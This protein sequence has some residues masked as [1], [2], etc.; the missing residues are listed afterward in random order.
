MKL[1]PSK[2]YQL[3]T[4]KASHMDI[5][6]DVQNVMKT[7]MDVFGVH[8]NSKEYTKGSDKGNWDSTTEET[9]TVNID[10]KVILI[11]VNK[12]NISVKII[13]IS[14]LNNLVNRR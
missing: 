1:T 11:Y 12:Q 4:G 8:R 5:G 13:Y 9:S 6:M 14:E 2:R 10:S 3:K 7:L